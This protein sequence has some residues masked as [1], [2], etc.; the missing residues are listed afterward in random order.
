MYF[1]SSAFKK[2]K[3]MKTSNLLFINLS[4]FFI[5]NQGII[6]ADND[7]APLKPGNRLVCSNCAPVEA[8]YNKGAAF[9]ETM[10]AKERMFDLSGLVPVKPKEASFD[11]E[12]FSPDTLKLI[13]LAPV[14]PREAGFTDED[15]TP[16]VEIRSLAP[17][18]PLWAGF[19]D[20]R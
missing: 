15:T 4:L 7:G 3:T 18:I 14:T 2:Q 16:T 17:K 12:T 9:N 11:Y 8:G 19:E 13:N 6:F 1:C 10:I 20:L 5:F